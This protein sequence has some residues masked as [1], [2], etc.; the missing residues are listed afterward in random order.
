MSALN[1]PPVV[2]SVPSLAISKYL[3]RAAALLLLTPFT[4]LAVPAG[5]LADAAKVEWHWVVKIPLR[6]GVRTANDLPSSFIILLIVKP[7]FSRW[8]IATPG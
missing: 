1:M 2:A 5:D 8:V 7:M 6:D 4:A 3:A